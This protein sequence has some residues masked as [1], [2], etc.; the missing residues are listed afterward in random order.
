LEEANRALQERNQDLDDFAHTVSHDIKEPLRGIQT[1]CWTL[2][3]DHGAQLPDS[4][5][6]PLERIHQLAERLHGMIDAVLEYS[7]LGRRT[8]A[9]T[10]DLN[11]LLQEARDM[12]YMTLQ[13]R[14]CTVCI[15]RPLP[16]VE[17]D[18]TMTAEI[19]KNLLSNASKYNDK[20][21][22]TIEVGW[23]AS[24]DGQGVK[25]FVRDNGIGIDPLQHE[26][27]F[28]VFHRLRQ[29]GDPGEG[30]GAG[31]AIVKKLVERQGGRVWV[32]ST[33]GEG[34]TFW[35]TLGSAAYTPDGGVQ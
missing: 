35:F 4:V 2:A 24:A 3:E 14:G 27:V 20:E 8:F 13:Q 23:A 11:D 34:S 9:R 17:C 16:H 6:T 15:P 19:F 32:E 10:L 7:R 21:E 26:H 5:R 25:I 31:L 30:A 1:Y 33:P 22:K 12:L 29:G 18:P 28:R